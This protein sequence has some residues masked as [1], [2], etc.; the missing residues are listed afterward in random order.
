MHTLRQ[1]HD[2]HRTGV[3]TPPSATTKKKQK[4]RAMCDAAGK[5]LS[6][7]DKDADPA[8]EQK[9]RKR[10]GNKNATNTSKAGGKGNKK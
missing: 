4:K 8:T 2:L 10:K 1:V 5:S 3:T 7:V 6:A 9:R